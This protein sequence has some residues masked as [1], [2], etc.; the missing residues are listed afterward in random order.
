MHSGGDQPIG[1][2]T[3]IGVARV[4]G[5]WGVSMDPLFSSVGS[6]YYYI[7]YYYILYYSRLRGRE[8]KTHK[9]SVVGTTVDN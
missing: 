2:L 6:S 1:L 3:G 7:L 4:R 8:R 5:S 9:Q